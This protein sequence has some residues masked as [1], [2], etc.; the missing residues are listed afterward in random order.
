MEGKKLWSEIG[1][2]WIVRADDL[3]M[4]IRRVFGCVGGCVGVD[5]WVCGCVGMRVCG[6]VC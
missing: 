2:C 5:V 4:Q 6:Y 1:D 3:M